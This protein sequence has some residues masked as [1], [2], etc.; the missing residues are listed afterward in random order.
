[1]TESMPSSSIFAPP[2]RD[3]LEFS[4]TM[5]SSVIGLTIALTLTRPMICSRADVDLLALVD[6]ALDDA[7]ARAAVVSPTMTDW[8]TSQSLRV[9]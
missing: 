6:G 3:H 8:A 4:A 2:R 1:M 5:V 7:A 9:R